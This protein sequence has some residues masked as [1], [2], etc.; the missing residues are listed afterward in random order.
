MVEDVEKRKIKFMVFVSSQKFLVDFLCFLSWQKFIR[1]IV[2]VLCFVYNI[3]SFYLD[4]RNRGSGLLLLEEIN[5]VEMFWIVSVQ[6]E[7]LDWRDCYND[8]VLFMDGKIIRVGG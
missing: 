1:V 4:L 7:L 5:G 3:K 2:Y 6:V 8:F